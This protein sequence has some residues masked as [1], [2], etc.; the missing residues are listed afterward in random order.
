VSLPYFCYRER[1]K[2]LSQALTP[3]RC[4]MGRNTKRRSSRYNPST[5][6]KKQ[7]RI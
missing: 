4:N 2:L 1:S 7:E 6:D 3:E 5:G